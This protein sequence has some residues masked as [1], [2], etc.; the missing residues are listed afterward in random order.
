MR[1]AVASIDTLTGAVIDGIVVSMIVTV[2]VAVLV[3]PLLSV[4]VQM[5]VVSPSGNVSGASLEMVTGLN[6]STA[7]ARP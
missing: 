6:M 5:I 7:V 1:T 2:W 4:A 3:R